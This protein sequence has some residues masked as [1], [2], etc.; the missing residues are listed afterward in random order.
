MNSVFR[1]FETYCVSHLQNT[2]YD[3]YCGVVANGADNAYQLAGSFAKRLQDIMGP[4]A[5]NTKRWVWDLSGKEFGVPAQVYLTLVV[6]GIASNLFYH[7]KHLNKKNKPILL[8]QTVA[9]FPRKKW[10]DRT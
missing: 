3:S 4:I 8:Q 2:G 5:V 7:L 10:A 1:S 6:I 9:D